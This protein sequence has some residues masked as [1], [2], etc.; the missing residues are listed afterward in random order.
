MLRIDIAFILDP[1]FSFNANPDKDLAPT[2][3]LG[4]VN[5]WQFRIYH[6]TGLQ[7]DFW[8]IFQLFQGNKC[9]MPNE[10]GYRTKC[11]SS[12]TIQIL[13]SKGR[14]R[15]RIQISRLWMRDP[16][17]DGNFFDKEWQPVFRIRIQMGQRI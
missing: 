6:A 9:A 5:N 7:H 11:E 4:Q 10:L 1:N 3:K 8:R 15:S 14:L 17:N 16:E 2:L 13:M 12:K